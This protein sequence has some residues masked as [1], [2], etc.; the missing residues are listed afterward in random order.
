M[1]AAAATEAGGHE[2]AASWRAIGT[3]VH[4]LVTDVRALGPARRLLRDDLAALDAA[5]SRF[6]TR[7]HSWTAAPPASAP[8]QNGLSAEIT[9]TAS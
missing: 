2:A 3:S 6:R 8:G 4:L 5:C 9:R 7:C 1:S